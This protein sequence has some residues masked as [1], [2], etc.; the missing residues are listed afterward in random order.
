MR[1]ALNGGKEPSSMPPGVE[2]G[3]IA[4]ARR[5]IGSRLGKLMELKQ[6]GE[7]N[8]GASSRR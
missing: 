5:G 8:P 7:K 2:A 3:F 6:R 1:V 4:F